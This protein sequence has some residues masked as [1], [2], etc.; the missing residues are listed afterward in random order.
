MNGSFGRMCVLAAL[1]S[2]P[3]SLSAAYLLAGFIH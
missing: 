3:A 1:F 2:F